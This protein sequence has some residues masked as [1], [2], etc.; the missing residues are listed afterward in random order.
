[1]SKTQTPICYPFGASSNTRV[2]DSGLFPDAFTFTHP[3]GLSCSALL[4]PSDAVSSLLRRMRCAPGSLNATCLV[5][6]L[7][8]GQ[9]ALTIQFLLGVLFPQGRWLCP[10]FLWSVPGHLPIVPRPLPGQRHAMTACSRSGQRSRPCSETG[11]SVHHYP[12]FT[13]QGKSIPEKAL[14]RHFC[15]AVGLCPCTA[16]P[17]HTAV[18]LLCSS[19]L[20]SPSAS[21]HPR[22]PAP[23]YRCAALL[24]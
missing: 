17:V 21:P 23:S 20:L 3:L 13:L 5:P 12:P 10:S 8:C 11:G 18:L 6:V 16:V 2:K 9:H 14:C 19:V 24:L 22:F 7:S 4:P 15:G 1:M